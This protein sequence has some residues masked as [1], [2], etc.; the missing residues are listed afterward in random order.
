M[1]YKFLFLIGKVLTTFKI[2][3]SGYF[4]MFPFLIGKVLTLMLFSIIV[5]MYNAVS[6]PYR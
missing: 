2:K 3:E 5:P 1:G 6:I 4:C